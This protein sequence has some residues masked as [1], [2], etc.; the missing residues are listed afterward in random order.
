MSIMNTMAV[1]GGT[2]TVLAV[3]GLLPLHS[4]LPEQEEF[5][6]SMHA[7]PS[8]NPNGCIKVMSYRLIRIAV[9]PLQNI[10]G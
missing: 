2:H 3:A 8:C 6:T 1:R 10:T 9:M 5:K 7:R 4:S